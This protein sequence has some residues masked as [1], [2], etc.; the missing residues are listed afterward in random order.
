MVE[1]FRSIPLKQK[2]KTKQNNKRF[3]LDSQ[4]KKTKSRDRDSST[5]SLRIVFRSTAPPYNDLIGWGAKHDWTR[6]ATLDWLKTGCSWQGGYG[7]SIQQSFPLSLSN[8]SS[9]PV[10]SSGTRAGGRAWWFSLFLLL[11][12]LLFSFPNPIKSISR[13][14]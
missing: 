9:F 5:T 12:L 7:T 1:L 4:R 3:F 14:W 2:N 8:V 10:S 11:L 6:K 13:S